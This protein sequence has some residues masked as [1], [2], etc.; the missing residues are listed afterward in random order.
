MSATSR[1]SLPAEP[2]LYDVDVIAWAEQ[3]AALLRAGRLEELDIAHIAEEIEDVGKSE[4][5]E[6]ASRMTVLLMHLLRW[7]YQPERRGS[8]W[9]NTIAAQRHAIAVRIKRTPSLQATLRDPA[10]WEGVWADAVAAATAETG[11]GDF[12]AVCPWPI[13]AIQDTTWLP[14]DVG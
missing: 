11:L 8:S 10:W 9:R 4:Q 14:D 5:R 13:S 3:Q 6:L 7:R 12:P 1:I 2:D